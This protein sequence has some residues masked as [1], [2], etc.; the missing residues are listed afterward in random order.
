[1]KRTALSLSIALGATLTL[2]SGTLG[3]SRQVP[4]ATQKTPVVVRNATVHTVSGETIEEDGYII[5]VD[6]VI[7]DVGRGAPDVPPG[8]EIIDAEGL[9]VYPGL[10][11]TATNIGLTETGSVS[12]TQDNSEL[13]DFKPEVRAAVAVNPDSE[14]LPVTRANGITTALIMPGGGLVSGRASVIRMD[15]WTWEDLAVESDAGLVVNWPRT[16]PFGGRFM[17]R[18]TSN[19]SQRLTESI[20]RLDDYFDQ[21]Q[22]YFRAK[23]NDPTQNTNSRFEAI[24]GVIAGEKPVYVRANSADQIES[25]VAWA[26]RR[27]L[28]IVIVGGAQA[29]G[30]IPILKKHEVPVIIDGTHR[31]PQRRHDDYDQPFT[32]AN[33]LYEAGVLFCIASGAGAAHERNLNHNVATAAAYGLP[34]QEALK[35]VT[36]NAA[37]IMGMGDELGSIEPG[38]SATLIL[39]TGDPLEITTDTL[40]AFIDGRNIDLA[41]RHTMLYEKYQQKYRQLGLLGSLADEI[42]P[43]G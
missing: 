7:T 8:A 5:F 1:M 41:S 20:K 27:G 14:H 19:Q 13:G 10:V 2:A 40:A 9:H 36:L 24:R 18:R 4:A 25:A 33:K 21:A 22:D 37:K 29:E 28:E 16:S 39:T 17:R 11:A 31:L 34:K 26:E 6:G 35:A 3:Q 15:G 43:D 30:A 38:K 32:L 12:E 23:D 42:D